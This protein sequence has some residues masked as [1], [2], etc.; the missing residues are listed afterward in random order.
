MV[1]M[2]LTAAAKAEAVPAPKKMERRDNLD[3]VEGM[4]S[5]LKWHAY[6]LIN[7]SE[8]LESNR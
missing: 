1:G 2:M 5:L 4:K 7:I 8:W 3:G 6:E